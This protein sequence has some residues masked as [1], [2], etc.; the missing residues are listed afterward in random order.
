LVMVVEV[1]I[2]ATDMNRMAINR[3]EATRN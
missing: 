3:A 2:E 1:N